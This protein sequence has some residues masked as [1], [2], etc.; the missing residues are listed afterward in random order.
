M[1]TFALPDRH[2][3]G[4]TST[5][6]GPTGANSDTVSPASK[7]RVP[8]LDG[9][10][11]IAIAL[12]LC[13]HY[14]YFSP[15]PNHHPT[16]L[17]RRIYVHLERFTALGWSGV[18]L[19]F[20]LS[21]F[22]IGGILLDARGSP[23]YFKAF[24][25]RRVF[26]IL[27]IYYAWIA[28]YIIV[29]AVAGRFLGMH[30]SGGGVPESWSTIAAQFFFLQNF[31]SIAY[32]GIAVAWF[33]PTWSLAVEEQFYIVAPAVI[34]FFTRRGLY[35]FLGAVVLLAPLLRLYLR[36]QFPIHRQDEM[37]LAYML[38][39]CRADALAIGI[40]T[41]LLWRNHIFRAWL[42]E[43]GRTLLVGASVFF[44]GVAA[45]NQWAPDHDSWQEQSAG[46][47]W[48]AI[49]YALLI[50]LVLSKQ[51]GWVAVFTRFAWLRELGK[52]SYCVY[53][54]HVAV[55]IFCRILVTSVVHRLSDWI[56][57]VSNI[58]AVFVSL[59]IARVSWAYFENPLLKKGHKYKYS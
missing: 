43:H 25:A 50:L 13:Y 45:L 34:H 19:F 9:L 28:A 41:A 56:F 31:H 17:I 32:T 33:L 1:R 46:Y 53:L 18:D 44:A 49:F 26:R 3:L 10:R 21:G 2:R 47:T 6:I 22:L 8:E 11:G 42:S 39:P 54:I 4:L 23:N 30:V 37:S 38:T 7:S 15:G 59:A 58:A 20:V 29:M 24:Y 40:L 16:E 12:V 36:H 14:F 55:M 5:M 51:G 57:V 52:V 27:P 35:L 48:I